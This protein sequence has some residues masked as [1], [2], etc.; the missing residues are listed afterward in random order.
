MAP[1][2]WIYVEDLGDVFSYAGTVDEVRIKRRLYNVGTRKPFTPVDFVNTLKEVLPG[3][4][5]NVTWRDTPTES[6]LNVAGPSGLDM[7]C[8]RFYEDL[9]YQG[10]SNLKQSIQRAVEFE[11]AR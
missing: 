1:L 8:S 5:I 2:R 3:A 6:A 9:G 4:K 10:D 11:R 7:D